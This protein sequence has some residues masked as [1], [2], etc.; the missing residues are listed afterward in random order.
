MNQNTSQKRIYLCYFCGQG[1]L[2]DFF[3]TCPH[4]TCRICFKNGYCI[5][6]INKQFRAEVQNQ[7]IYRVPKKRKFKDLQDSCENS[8]N[9]SCSI[10]S[11]TRQYSVRFEKKIDSM[12]KELEMLDYSL[13][14]PTTFQTQIKTENKGDSIERSC[15]RTKL[16]N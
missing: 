10:E 9:Q 11:E 2:G 16:F 4:F 12:I 1:H 5:L 7:L 3:S 6:C 15:K 14:F 8:F 13:H